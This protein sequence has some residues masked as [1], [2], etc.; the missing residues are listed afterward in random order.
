MKCFI[1][2]LKKKLLNLI[3]LTKRHLKYVYVNKYLLKLNWKMTWTFNKKLYS[4]KIYKI[5]L[6]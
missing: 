5:I 6:S 4:H 3:N 1:A 2:G